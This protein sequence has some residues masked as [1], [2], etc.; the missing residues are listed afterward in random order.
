MPIFV[1][2]SNAEF[3]KRYL[4]A[5]DLNS[6]GE[7]LLFHA[8]KLLIP[9]LDRPDWFQVHRWRY[10]FPSHPLTQDYLDAGAPLPLVCCGDWCGGNLIESAMNSGLAAAIQINSQ[11]Q[12]RSLPGETFF[13]AL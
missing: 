11:L 13:Y 10:A 9:W 6:A 12:K 5:E 2:Q 4:D 1:L 8:A 7:Q 3:A